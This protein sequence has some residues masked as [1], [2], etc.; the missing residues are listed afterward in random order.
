VGTALTLSQWFNPKPAGVTAA[1]D[2][3]HL[4]IYWVG[5]LVGGA[6]AAAVFLFQHPRDPAET[7]G[8]TAEAP[9]GRA[10]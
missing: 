9:K 10:A 6:L 1:A 4:W 7:P 2:F 5:P 3:S 8:G